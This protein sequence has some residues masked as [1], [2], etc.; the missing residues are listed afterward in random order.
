MIMMHKIL[1]WFTDFN[2]DICSMICCLYYIDLMIC[3][4]MFY[5]NSL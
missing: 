4:I 1:E 3:M 2:Y 5:N